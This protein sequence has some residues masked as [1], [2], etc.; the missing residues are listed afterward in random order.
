MF[1]NQLVY[2]LVTVFYRIMYVKCLKINKFT[3]LTP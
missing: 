1:E 2:Y 3:H